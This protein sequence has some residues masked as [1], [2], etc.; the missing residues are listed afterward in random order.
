[1]QLADGGREEARAAGPQWMAERD[2]AA[3]GVHVSG[4]V[5]QAER[6]Q[7]GQSLRREG[8]IELDDVHPVQAQAGACEQ[9]AHGGDRSE[10]HHPRGDSGG[11]APYHAGQ[12]C[13][14]VAG[15]G[16]LGGEQDGARAVIDSRGVARGDSAAGFD[17][18]PEGSEGFEGGGGTRVLVGID[19]GLFGNRHTG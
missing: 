3:V 10:P 12:R 13:E 7:H 16:G 18:R 19:C 6:A 17:D 2:G 1:M 15:G 8:L 4:I 9:L 14:T 5:G 11:G